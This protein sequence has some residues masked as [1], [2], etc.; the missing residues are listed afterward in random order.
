MEGKSK[1]PL[2][3]DSGKE[4]K[5]ERNE[6]DYCHWFR[7]GGLFL[8]KVLADVVDVLGFLQFS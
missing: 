4:T 2:G 5:S 3:K 7:K 1:M 6:M 8:L